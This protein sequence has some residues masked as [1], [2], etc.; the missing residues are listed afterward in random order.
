VFLVSLGNTS[1]LPESGNK[2]ATA[3][4]RPASLGGGDQLGAIIGLIAQTLVIGKYPPKLPIVEVAL[5]DQHADELRLEKLMAP[6]PTRAD[7][8]TKKR[9]NC[10]L[11]TGVVAAVG[12]AIIP[13]IDK[14][15][16][17]SLEALIR[18]YQ[19]NR[20]YSGRAIVAQQGRCV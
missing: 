16:F 1:S 4:Q 11:E 2:R 10:R 8:L 18:F 15:A 13:A 5:V 20:N 9:R 19:I 3:A 6:L 12:A 7:T 17:R 14:F